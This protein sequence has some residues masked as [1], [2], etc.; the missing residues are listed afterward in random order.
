M[1][2]SIETAAVVSPRI[3]KMQR[4]AAAIMLLAGIVNYLDRSTL[5]I[6]NPL[7]RQDLGLSIADMGLLLSAFL[8]A[9]AFSQLPAGA[10]VDR[11]GP[12]KLLGSAILLWS[13]AQV[14]AGFAMNFWQFVVARIFLGIGESPSFPSFVR[15]LREW[16]SVRDRAVP[17]SIVCSGPS[18]IGPA[19]APPLLTLLMVAIGWRSMI[20]ALGLIGVVVAFVWMGFYRDRKMVPLSASEEAYFAEPAES[21]QDA[22]ATFDGWRR[23][24]SYRTTWGV[25]LGN[26]GLIYLQWMYL[27]WLPGYLEIE[28]H[29]SISKTGLLASIPFLFGILGSI[30]GGW[31]GKALMSRGVS[32]IMSCKIPI[33]V[34]LTVA[35]LATAAVTLAQTDTAAI[36]A[37]SFALFFVCAASGMAWALTGIAAPKSYT[38]SLASIQN[39][40][41]YCGGALAPTITGFV[42]QSTG[43][44]GPALWTAAAM[45]FA[46][47]LAYLTV[48]PNRI[49]S[50][51]HEAN[52]AAIASSG[53]SG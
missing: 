4:R 46:S 28:R 52:R 39:F 30:G 44:F 31:C 35:A 13:A 51:E 29:V 53:A 19:I 1:D 37:I 24:F 45:G 16:H 11:I 25:V 7:V 50:F 26:F 14:A 42:V 38:S 21:S 8:W 5:A 36:A 12:R 23:L 17:T 49:E 33:V 48:I 40:S 22:A 47:A 43:T 34:G 10:I 9:Y 27:A 2:V 15:G 18:S 32:P 20:V 3:K 41:G 6:A